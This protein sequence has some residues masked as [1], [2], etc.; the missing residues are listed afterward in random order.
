M[1]CYFLRRPVEEEGK[2]VRGYRRRMQNIW[3]EQYGTEIT[4]QRLC[5]QARILKKNERITKLELKNIGTSK[6][7]TYRSINN[8]DNTGERFYQDE[9]NIHQNEATQV[10]T[11]NLGEEE[12]TVI[13]DIQ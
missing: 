9:E 1:E 4:E 6:R 8:N 12:N 7:K 13:Q 11:E 2:P 3:K 5:D 10:D